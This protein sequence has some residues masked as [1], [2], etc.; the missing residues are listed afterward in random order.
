MLILASTLP[1]SV[2]DL[3]FLL[4][5]QRGDLASEAETLGI[6]VHLLGLDREACATPGLTA[7]CAISVARALRRYRRLTRDVDIVDSWLVPAFTFAGV[8]QPFAR[9]PVLLAGRRSLHDTHR[10][11]TWYRDTAARLV[12]RQMS[13]IVANSEAAA[14]EAVSLEG[15]DPGR[16]HVIR[17][18]VVLLP[19]QERVR[20]ELRRVWGFSHDQIVAGCVANYRPGKGHDVL[21][22][23][24]ERL[25]D[26]CPELRWAF[27]GNGPLRTWLEGQIRTRNLDSHVV[28]HSGER[29]ARHVYAAFDIA[30]QASDTEG[31]PNAVLEAAAS[32]LPIVATDVGGTNEILTSE[33]HGILV[34]RGDREGLAEAIA[35]L[36]ADPNLR[37]RLGLAAERRARDF[38]PAKL[39]EETG[40]LYLRLAAHPTHAR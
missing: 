39:A 20:L 2:F 8:A 30:V 32:A 35:R 21:L 10:T 34:R 3:R 9:V 26:R 18:A 4:L 25:R 19:R 36:M 28:L 22:D 14:I 33:A 16:V 17:N 11:R 31:L 13:A 23:V 15:I 24:A 6:P 1:R 5:A 40:E 29:D 12:T 38:S 27:V 37:G 7:R